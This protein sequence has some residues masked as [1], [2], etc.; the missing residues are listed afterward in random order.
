VPGI[1]TLDEFVIIMGKRVKKV[2][3]ATVL[4]LPFVAIQAGAVEKIRDVAGAGI[5]CNN[6]PNSLAPRFLKYAKRSCKGRAVCTVKA[7]N[8]TG[9]KRLRAYGCTGFYVVASCGGKDK[10][11][12]SRG[13]R[14]KL[15][16]L[17]P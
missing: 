15:R 4:L 2:I 1:N 10:E 5:T 9:S 14:E 7:T 8:V 16:V 12:R 6:A 13:I 11:V 17:C 3:L